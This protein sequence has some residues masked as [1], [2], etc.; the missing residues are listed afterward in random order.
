MIDIHSEQLI[1]FP[2]APAQLP[3]RPAMSTLHRWRQQG[4]HG[5]RLETCLIGGKRFTSKE[6][7][8]R[9]ANA[10]TTA[11]D[12]FEREAPVNPIDH[13]VEGQLDYL[14]L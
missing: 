14:G 10:V 7:L 11:A 9:F 2:E 12:R 4:V 3:G 1:P 8:Q 6:A 5:I 13:D